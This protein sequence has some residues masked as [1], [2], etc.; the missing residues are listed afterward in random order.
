VTTLFIHGDPK[1]QPRPRSTT[2]NGHARIYSPRTKWRKTVERDLRNIQAFGTDDD[3]PFYAAGQPVHVELEFL[4][5]R[6]TSHLKKRGG[7]TKSAPRHP[8]GQ[9]SGDLDNAAKLVL[10]AANGLLWDDDAQVT[11]LE[12]EKRY[13]LPGEGGVR[14]TYRYDIEAEQRTRTE[15]TA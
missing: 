14:I 8:L 13:V 10:D 6:P 3:A 11:R 12:V 5:P 7:L 1:P 4:L 9:K 2:V 15:A